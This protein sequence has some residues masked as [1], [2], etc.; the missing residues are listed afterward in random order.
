[1]NSTD[2]LASFADYLDNELM[3]GDFS[4]GFNGDFNEDL[5]LH[6][7]L[8]HPEAPKQTV[9]PNPPKKRRPRLPPD[10]A[11]RKRA[12]TKV[13]ITIWSLLSAGYV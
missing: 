5:E 2:S 1:M 3:N 6:L 8:P 11:P 10:A 13:S 9:N 4:G 7:D 12:K